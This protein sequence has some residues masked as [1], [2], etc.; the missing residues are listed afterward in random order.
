MYFA[1]DFT[2]PEFTHREG[3]VYLNIDHPAVAWNAYRGVLF[4]RAYIATHHGPSL[5]SMREA[6]IQGDRD[7]RRYQTELALE[8]LRVAE[9]PGA[10]SRLSGMFVFDEVHSALS[11]LEAEW[12]GDY[13][14]PDYLTDVGVSYRK[15]TR[16]DANWISKM[17]DADASLKDGWEPMARAYWAGL[18]CEGAR[19]I[20]ELLID[21]FAAVWDTRLRLQ[22]HAIVKER[23]PKSLGLL[24]ESRIAAILGYS[25]G[26]ASWGVTSTENG[27]ELWFLIDTGDDL[28]LRYK[29]AVESYVRQC[30]VNNQSSIDWEALKISGNAALKPNLSMYALPFPFS[31]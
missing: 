24:E 27:L 7:T 16:M 9:F 30:A 5:L 28:D 12:G 4:S 13:I 21:G 2:N 6:V 17:L 8:E 18:P 20:W 29:P 26:N 19:P 23:Y 10:V 15:A 3:F 31:W 14:N 25:F 22:A 1:D 11:A